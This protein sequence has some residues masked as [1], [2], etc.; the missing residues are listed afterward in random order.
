MDARSVAEELEQ[1]G[2]RD[3]LMNASLTRLA[4]NGQ[5]GQPRVI[6]I[7]FLWIG[8]HVVICT[9]TTAPKVRALSDRPQ[10]ALTIDQG[11]TPDGAKALLI[12]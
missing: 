10:V 9:A 5:D 8:E 2:A 1:L 7:G 3:L 4:Y 6:P 11:D 12:R